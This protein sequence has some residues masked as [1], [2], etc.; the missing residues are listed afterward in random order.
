M[1]D[2]AEH[3][4]L[5]VYIVDGIKVRNMYKT[6]FVEGGTAFIYPFIPIDEIWIEDQVP[7]EER[8]FVLL[9]EFTE[10]DLMRNERA[11]YDDA[12]EQ[13]SKVEFAARAKWKKEGTVPEV[14]YAGNGNKDYSEVERPNEK[15]ENPHTENP[16]E[17]LLYRKKGNLF[18]AEDSKQPYA[19]K[20]PP[21]TPLQEHDTQLVDDQYKSLEQPHKYGCVMA[22]FPEDFRKEVTDWVLEN[23]PEC[24]LG[25]GGRE[26]EIHVT[27]KYGLKDSSPETVAALKGILTR[28]GPFKVKL[29]GL[30]I[31][32]EG[33]GKWNNKD[34]D[35]LK[36]DVEGAKLRELNALIS[37][38]FPCYDK[39]PDY[40]PHLT[41]AYLDPAIS[42]HYGNL[43]AP[44]ADREI[45][46]NEVVW[47]GADKERETIPLAFLPNL[48]TKA[49][50][51]EYD[52]PGISPTQRDSAVAEASRKLE[53]PSPPYGRGES[54]A[55]RRE[56]EESIV[57]E[58]FRRHSPR[59]TIS[60]LNEA[61]EEERQ[62]KMAGIGPAIRGEKPGKLIPPTAPVGSEVYGDHPVNRP[63]PTY[64]QYV[65]E[66]VAGKALPEQ[67]T[68]ASSP[69]P[70]SSSKA[71]KPPHIPSS[72]YRSSEHQQAPA[73][74]EAPD[75]T[76]EHAVLDK[77]K[78]HLEEGANNI[79]EGSKVQTIHSDDPNK[80][81]KIHVSIP[82]GDGRYINSSVR[83]TRD[84]DDYDR[85]V[86][87]AEIAFRRVE[88]YGPRGAGTGYTENSP[89]GLQSGTIGL[90]R[91]LQSYLD[92]L[93]RHGIRVSYAPADA[94]RN[95][96]YQKI[97]EQNGWHLVSE[98][99]IRYVWEPPVQGQKA[100]T[101]T[102]EQLRDLAK[103][104]EESEMPTNG[105]AMSWLGS[106]TGGDLVAPPAQGAPRPRRIVSLLRSIA[107]SPFRLK[108]LPLTGTK[109][110][111][112][113]QPSSPPVGKLP[114]GFS[115]QSTPVQTPRLPSSPVKPAQAPA[116]KAPQ[117]PEPREEKPVEAPEA[118]TPVPP[119]VKEV[120]SQPPARSR[121][122]LQAELAKL[123]AELAQ[124]EAG[125]QASPVAPKP[126]PQV[127]P[128]KKKP[129]P[130][131]TAPPS[132]P[133]L[134][135]LHAE[136]QK[137][138]EKV[139]ISET[140]EA[141]VK[142]I[143]DKLRSGSREERKAIINEIVTT[144]GDRL[145]STAKRAFPRDEAM[146]ND[147]VQEALIHFM[148]EINDGILERKP[149]MNYRQ[150]LYSSVRF[151]A[152]HLWEEI[153]RRGER[154]AGNTGG[155]DKHG[156]EAALEAAPSSE[157]EP[158]LEAHLKK[159]RAVQDI[160]NGA[161]ERDLDKR[162]QK[163]EDPNLSRL[164]RE[165]LLP[166]IK[167]RKAIWELHRR[168]Y[169]GD[170]IKNVLEK[171]DE[172]G[173]PGL[174]Q[175][176]TYRQATDKVNNTKSKF[177][178]V[179]ED[180]IE[181]LRQKGVLDSEEVADFLNSLT[182]QQANRGGRRGVENEEAE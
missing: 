15:P 17:S 128:E 54:A 61:R 179:S 146:A 55:A 85:L 66:D 57:D 86:P 133:F 49:A 25:P 72:P 27:V 69:P 36:V 123:Q 19:A 50:L 82:N 116:P 96:L 119:P 97:L 107:P 108:R 174:L 41:L 142:S 38:T 166:D 137:R 26:H 124:R 120:A 136:L 101:T 5:K 113:E 83:I 135:Q 43:E 67:T 6:D 53:N 63:K 103:S 34:G 7:E 153:R 42:Q 59:P 147:V 16:N 14:G 126:V 95:R 93:A 62:G 68:P 91:K 56:E 160:I 117:A 8:P 52:S 176:M 89:E 48:G 24:H 40:K 47:S 46:V 104:F 73:A 29:N 150:L 4:V 170:Q 51:P 181:E 131:K 156:I 167:I 31:F 161:I 155:E 74:P 77:I 112:E 2:I 180:V 90:M 149:D 134:A 127:E 33:Y 23:V 99:K 11:D 80:A 175:G 45:M 21:P 65:P 165:Q 122:E 151:T 111:P 18:G 110:L 94:R 182:E 3:E 121:E 132:D 32:G 140:K 84:V 106:G 157:L 130:K 115:Y 28:F 168:G 92:H 44:F 79:A 159:Y 88:G 70:P 58:A 78:P 139:P 163:A 173:N 39:Y 129:A 171:P 76:Q 12:H 158:E 105:K 9:H 152:G 178:D 10:R 114:G 162:Q 143:T 13:A 60:K 71:P 145:L 141:K 98:S 1:N 35:V 144:E 177:R 30:S 102:E 138:G 20:D 75:Y 164:Q 100:L 125:E 118:Q 37:S 22:F 87:E 172:N 109:A 169:S 154:T 64:P 148:N 81:N